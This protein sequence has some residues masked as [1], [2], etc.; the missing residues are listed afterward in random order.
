M[1]DTTL[2]RV[3][4]LRDVVQVCSDM[5]ARAKDSRSSS[6]RGYFAHGFFAKASLHGQSICVLL[7]GYKGGQIELDVGGLCALSRCIM[8]VNNASR[9]LFEPKISK[10]EAEFRYQLF[11]LNHA[12]DLK[13]I[14]TG[15]GISTSDD[16]LSIQEFSRRW[17]ES[18]LVKNPIFQSLDEAHKK[19]L[20]KGKS[21]YLTDRYKG[22]KLLEKTVESA[23][24]NLFSHSVHSF[25][26]GLSPGMRGQH[27]PAGEFHMIF[28]AV[29]M[30]LM[31]LGAM[32]LDYWRLRARAI[33]K[34]STAEKLL[35]KSAASGAPLKEWL[36]NM[37]AS[38]A[39]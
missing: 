22:E 7:Q 34:L 6:W 9:Y 32:A 35:L 29:E 26:L 24:Y 20:L 28:L 4:V 18:E 2:I 12:T 30:A 14:S 38:G 21:P 10:D 17:S 27:T 11:L 25:S 36:K 16:R 15:F 8:E 1:N 23:A 37:A 33:K 3:T 31:H 13:K 39:F 19:K 5:Q